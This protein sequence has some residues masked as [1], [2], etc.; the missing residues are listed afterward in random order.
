MPVLIT[1]NK[2]HPMTNQN[3]AAPKVKHKNDG[4]MPSKGGGSVTRR[5]AATHGTQYKS[6]ES[7]TT[8]S[9]GTPMETKSHTEAMSG[10]ESGASAKGGPKHGKSFYGK[11]TTATSEMSQAIRR[12]QKHASYGGY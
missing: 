6:T 10:A 4:I 11:L 2:G 3:N 12:K 1:G 9:D 8:H 5:Q 7:K